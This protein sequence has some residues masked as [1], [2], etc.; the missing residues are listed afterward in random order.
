MVYAHFVLEVF[1]DVQETVVHAWFVP[2]LGFN[3][4]EIGECLCNIERTIETV[5]CAK[6]H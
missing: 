4:V 5:R 2:K 6:G 1:H 3:G